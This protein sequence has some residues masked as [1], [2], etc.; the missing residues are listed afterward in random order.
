MENQIIKIQQELEEVKKRNKRVES[1]KGWEVSKVRVVFIL[2]IT[3]VVASSVL[4][5]IKVDNYLLGALIPTIGYFLSTLTLSI[6]KKWW[7]R[8]YFDVK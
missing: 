3:Y 7:I 8:K 1:D 2:I 4:Y 6:V 5:L